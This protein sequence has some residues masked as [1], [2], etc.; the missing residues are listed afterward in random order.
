MVKCN[1]SKEYIT[2]IELRP[3][4]QVDGGPIKQAQK[5]H[6][7]DITHL[8]LQGLSRSCER[9][10]GSGL[11]VN[12]E[13]S[14]VSIGEMG[15]ELPTSDGGFNTAVQMGFVQMSGTGEMGGAFL[16]S[17]EEPDRAVQEDFAPTGCTGSG[18]EV[19]ALSTV[20]VAGDPTTGCQISGAVEVSHVSSFGDYPR[21]TDAVAECST[22]PVKSVR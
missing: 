20:L 17:G 6:T 2:P 18:A 1:F 22:T 4:K 8:K 14:K 10:E 11:Q 15:G 5:D 9:G 21:F 12:V 7:G 19:G 3:V 16:T 13:K